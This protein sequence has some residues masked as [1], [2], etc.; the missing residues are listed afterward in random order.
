[1]CLPA[2][3][4][5][6]LSYKCSIL[7]S[8]KALG[9]LSGAVLSRMAG[10]TQKIHCNMMIILSHSRVTDWKSFLLH[11]HLKRH[12]LFMSLNKKNKPWLPSCTEWGHLRGFCRGEPAG[13]YRLAL[14]S[15]AVSHRKGCVPMHPDLKSTWCSCLTNSCHILLLGKMSLMH[16]LLPVPVL[17]EQIR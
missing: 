2:E 5:F 12:R 7:R 3:N 11:P 10:W 4:Y 8:D 17:G 14:T 16:P 9:C 6:F 15:P 1:M 13:W